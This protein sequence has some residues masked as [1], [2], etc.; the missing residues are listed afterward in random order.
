[1][2]I[3]VSL[4]SPHTILPPIPVAI[5]VI[6]ITYTAHHR[7]Q[8]RQAWMNIRPHRLRRLHRQH[9]Y[10]GYNRIIQY[11]IIL[12][13]EFYLWYEYHSRLGL[14]LGISQW[15]SIYVACNDQ[16]THTHTHT[17]TKYVRTHTR[18]FCMGSD[19]GRPT[20]VPVLW[21]DPDAPGLSMTW[22]RLFI[23]W[24]WPGLALTWPGPDPGPDLAWP[25]RA[26][27]FGPGGLALA[28]PGP[29][30]ALTWPDPGPG[31]EPWPWPEPDLAW[32][33]P[34]ALAWPGPERFLVSHLGS[35][36]SCLFPGPWAAPVILINRPTGLRFIFAS[37]NRRWWRCWPVMVVHGLDL[38]MTWLNDPNAF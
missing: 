22:W 2:I 34:L 30:L 15:D 16:N 29:G 1:M 31:P 38:R 19:V 10:C 18:G 24:A 4:S 36:R 6:C 12:V 14:G 37:L 33:W 35:W 27:P 17:Y 11:S 9:S 28:W 3:I 13:V 20:P 5:I 26:W 21:H 23:A 32:P 25:E 8:D 7:T